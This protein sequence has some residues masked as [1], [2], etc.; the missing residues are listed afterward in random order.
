[1]YLSMYELERGLKRGIQ[2]NTNGLRRRLVNRIQ[3]MCLFFCSSS[4]VGEEMMLADTDNLGNRYSDDDGV[5][6]WM[7]RSTEKELFRQEP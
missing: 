2:H 4:E 7:I 3:V 1:M 5:R 6:A